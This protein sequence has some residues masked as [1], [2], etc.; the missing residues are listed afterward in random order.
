MARK[1]REL[2]SP[3]DRV[4]FTL[5]RAGVRRTRDLARMDR[6][7]E[8][9][10]VRGLIE[11]WSATDVVDSM[12]QSNLRKFAVHTDTKLSRQFVTESA[13]YA[14]FT[15][16]LMPAISSLSLAKSTQSMPK[17]AGGGA[18][19]RR[20]KNS[21]AKSAQSV[22]GG[23]SWIALHKHIIHNTLVENLVRARPLVEAGAAMPL[24][25]WIDNA[26]IDPSRKLSFQWP[27]VAGRHTV[28]VN[29]TRYQ[30]AN[31]YLYGG[32]RPNGFVELALPTLRAT[33]LEAVVD[34]RREERVAF[35]RFT[36]CFFNMVNVA[37]NGIPT[38][39]AVHSAIEEVDAGVAE[40]QA[41]FVRIRN[42]YTHAQLEAA[43]QLAA[44][45]LCLLVPEGL[46]KVLA[47]L[48]A[49]KGG[50]ALLRNFSTYKQELANLKKS[51]FYVPWLITQ[52]AE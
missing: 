3:F 8:L 49:G 26:G 14:D 27:I 39:D 43:T 47:G 41:E 37:Q 15:F 22:S 30:A 4:Y 32:S 36:K 6:K 33:N 28:D 42:K 35:E 23:E 16:F 13:L 9:D 34:V 2:D 19:L 1:R 38:E 10:I 50:S 20:A 7:V 31:P 5:D 48:F 11:V 40:L 29:L 45:C 52:S 12:R 25:V 18:W 24:P 17:D 44:C 46:A 21:L 51:D